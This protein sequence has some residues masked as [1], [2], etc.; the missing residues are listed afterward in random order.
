VAQP[1][2]PAEIADWSRAPLLRPLPPAARAERGPAAWVAALHAALAFASAAC[3]PVLAFVLGPLLFGVPHVAAGVRHLVLRRSPAAPWRYVLLGGCVLVFAV[4]LA[5]ELAGASWLRAEVAVVLCW[6]AAAIVTTAGEARAPW[7]APVAGVVLAVAGALA[8]SWP[9]EARLVL[10]H[11][12]NLLALCALSLFSARLG[13]MRVLVVLSLAGAVLLASGVLFELTLALGAKAF[14]IHVLQTADWVAPGLRADHAIGV[15]TAYVYL[16]L[17][18]YSIWL[19]FIPS[20]DLRS[21]DPSSAP[22]RA[23][24]W[25][26]GERGR[27]LYRDLKLPGAV[28]LAVALVAMLAGSVVSLQRTRVLYLSLATFHVYLE[29]ILLTRSWLLGSGAAVFRAAPPAPPSST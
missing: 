13:S 11:L 26:L 18:H 10:L 4:R 8:W 17:V 28:L 21:A 7:R 20:A 9:S 2:L 25:P 3:F 27:R 19:Y 24:A 23:S 1:S 22:P 29:V 12:H 5:Q 14:G 15:T 6:A 16:Q